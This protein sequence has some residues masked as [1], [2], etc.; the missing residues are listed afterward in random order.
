MA[1][2]DAESAGYP[3]FSCTPIDS[4]AEKEEWGSW[5]ATLTILCSHP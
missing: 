2:D 3:A 1:Y 4:S 5:T